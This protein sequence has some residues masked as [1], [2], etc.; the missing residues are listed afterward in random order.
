[1]ANSGQ[2]AFSRKSFVV[3]VVFLYL[4]IAGLGLGLYYDEWTAIVFGL[5]LIVVGITLFSIASIRNSQGLMR[6]MAN[7]VFHEKIAIM[8]SAAGKQQDQIDHDRQAAGEF[9]NWADPNLRQEFE[10]L[11]QQFFEA[12]AQPVVIKIG[13]STLGDHDTTL[14]DV[15]NLHQRGF[16]PVVVHGGGTK[17][18][19]WL[20][21]M[22]ISTNFVQGQ[23]VTDVETLQVVVAVLAGLVNKELVAAIN[24]LD[25]KAIGLS[26]VDGSLIQA[27]IERPG[28]GYVGEVV[29]INP[30]SIG[31]V[32]AAGYVPVIAPGG[33]RLP[34]DYN[35]PVKLLNINGDVGA[36]EIA[37]A[38]KAG[39]LI[40]LTDVPGVQDSA[41]NLM[42]RLTADEARSLIDSGVISGGMIP[43]VEGCLRA[44]S[45]VS[46][47]QIV[48]G[49]A[50]GALISAVEGE[51]I[52]TVIQ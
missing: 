5:A 1:M 52:G 8:Q 40:F 41:G 15:V 39:K 47:T 10:D 31:A 49:R 3:G 36:S 50:E 4:G 35:D 17:I 9:E 45:A 16:V 2:K 44:L 48:D 34:G 26:G 30:E 19:E 27:K 51:G 24:A 37:V 28:M 20:S 21:R 33:F 22:G 23:R 38:L 6:A 42:P 32:V 18:T 25:G 7:L 13:G 46:S 29:K 11:W 12:G 43:K 14:R